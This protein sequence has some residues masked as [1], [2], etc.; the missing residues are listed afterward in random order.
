MKAS[1]KRLRDLHKARA[2]IV[3]EIAALG[4]VLP[5]VTSLLRAADRVLDLAIAELTGELQ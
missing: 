3:A 1:K 4:Y 5:Q 2:A